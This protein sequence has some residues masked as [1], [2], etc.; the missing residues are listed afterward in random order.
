[1]M[2]K[3]LYKRSYIGI[4]FILCILIS[5]SFVLAYT[6]SY[7]SSQNNNAIGIGIFSSGQS[8][9]VDDSMCQQG[10]DFLIQIGPLACTP[11]PVRS[12][13]LAEENVNV[14]CQMTATQINPFVDVKRI[15]T[16]NFIT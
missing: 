12:D 5:S 11:S 7:Y 8:L 13:L 15:D 1:M 9:K 3:K 4:I 6:Q 14:F 16:I 2:N 10:D